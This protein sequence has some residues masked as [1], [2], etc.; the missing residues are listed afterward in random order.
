MGATPDQLKADIERTRGQ[1]AGDVETLTEKIKPGN[2]VRRRTRA[3]SEKARAMTGSVQ[4]RMGSVQGSVQD[5]VGS[6]QHAPT[7][8]RSRTTSNPLAYGLIAFGAG[9]LAAAALPTS[10]KE[11]ELGGQVKNRAGDLTA[12]LADT[13]KQSVQQM[14]EELEPAARQAVEQ[15]KESAA[16]AAQ[17]TTKQAKSAADDVASTA[18]SSGRS[19]KSRAKASR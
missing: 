19:V 7:M 4:D 12:P 14:R 8:M 18:K 17:R 16:G 1:L 13:A 2:V 6:V 5:G 9:L 15:V 3:V 10:E 11:K